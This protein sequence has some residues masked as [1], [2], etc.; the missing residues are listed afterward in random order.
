MTTAKVHPRINFPKTIRPMVIF[1]SPLPYYIALPEP[2]FSGLAI[3]NPWIF[4]VMVNL[5]IPFDP[6]PLGKKKGP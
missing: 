2:N 6:Y 5:K 3:P 1:L 4:E